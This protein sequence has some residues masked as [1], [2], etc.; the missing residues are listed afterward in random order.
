MA[1]VVG[2]AT[3]A[4]RD[5]ELMAAL[6]AQIL[7]RPRL[8]VREVLDRAVARGEI[9]PDREIGLVPDV[10]VGLNALRILLGEAPDRA[11][12]RRV[13]DEIVYPLVTRPPNEPANS[14]APA[15]S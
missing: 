10:L 4:S 8:L 12:V 11:F 7:E 2:V 1:V 6:S 13:F 3:A 9:P 5:P 14:R 15:G